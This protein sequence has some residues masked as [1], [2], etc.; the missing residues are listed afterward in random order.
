MAPNYDLTFRPTFLSKQG[1]LGDVEWRHRLASGVYNIRGAGIFQ[2]DPSAYLPSP[3]GPR[4]RDFRG[5]LESTGQFHIN[6]RWKWGWDVSLLTDKWFL[7]HYRIRSESLAVNYYSFKES[8][9]TLYLQG[10]GDRS[11]FEARGYYFKTLSTYDWQKQLPVVHPVIDYN[12]RVDGP[13]PLGG[14]VSVDVNLTSLTRQTA[15]FAQVPR[16]TTSLFG[17]Y[18]TCTVFQ[19]GQCIVRGLSGTYSRL[20]TQASWRRQFIDPAGQ[21]WIPFAYVRADGFWNSPDV[22]GFQNAQILNFMG[23]DEDFVGRVMPAAG[24]EYR[25]PFIAVTESAGTHTIE[26]IAQIVARPNEGRIGRLPNE[27]SHSL[28]YDD[29]SLFDWD[30]FA[31]YDRAEGGVRANTALRYS[32]SGANGFYGDAMF[33]QSFQLA[34]RNSFTVGDLLNTGR[35]SGLESSASDYVGRL[36]VA[37]N[38]NISFTTR[39]RFDEEDLTIRRFEA[40]FSGSFAP[41]LPLSGSLIYA[42]YA[43]QPELGI[44]RRREGFTASARY[45]LNTQWWVS[46]SV[47]VDLDRYLIAR[48]TF[49]NQYTNYVSSLDTASPL[50]L[51]VYNRDRVWSVTGTSLGVGYSD[52][53]TTF[54]IQ[55]SMAPRELANGTTETDKMVLVR[56]ELRTLGEVNYRQTVGQ[57]ATQDGISP[58]ANP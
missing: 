5:V 39:A 30:K 6:E 20:S 56:L 7:Q 22:T 11:W 40:G 42:R 2:Q 26:P 36:H 3:L 46:G 27:D 41:Y 33:G 53:C 13:D 28:V 15:Q 23:G 21:V 25:Y 48:E 58:S 24:V 16:P 29:T 51:P 34:G 8:V 31:G 47:L 17:L 45:S 35:D 37:P 54:S 9:S 38:K 1:V 19:R 50:A 10:Q 55:Y 32:V 44:D 12:K 52:E 57:E 18:E 4:E 14:E 49:A 43:P